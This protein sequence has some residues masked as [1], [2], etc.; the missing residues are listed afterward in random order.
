MSGKKI[1]EE[2]TKVDPIKYLKRNE[3]IE[4]RLKLGLVTHK[5]VV[6]KC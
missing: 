1:P 2:Y 6:D 3:R 4:F 5:I